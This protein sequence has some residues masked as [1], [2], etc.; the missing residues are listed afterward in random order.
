MIGLET[1]TIKRATAGTRERGRYTE[2]VP[3]ESP[4]EASIQPATAK[5][6]SEYLKGGEVDYELYKGYT[7]EPVRGI[8]KSKGLSA[9]E[10]FYD[11]S[12]WKVIKTNIYGSGL[13]AHTKF[14]IIREA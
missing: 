14:F 2:G 3:I 11:E 4:F 1:H 5:E 6:T 9:D 12:W 10:I 13:D 8:R 7:Y